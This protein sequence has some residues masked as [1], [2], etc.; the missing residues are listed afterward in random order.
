MV[1]PWPLIGRTEEL[2]RLRESTAPA[3]R[4]S[5]LSGPAGVGKT[6]LA[7]EVFAYWQGRGRRCR[8]FVGTRSAQSVP[9]AAH[10]AGVIV[11]DTDA[12]PAVARLAHPLLGEVRR[13]R[14]LPT[15][16]QELRSKVARELEVH[17]NAPAPIMLVRR[18]V[19]MCGSDL[20]PDSDLLID[21]ARAALR[22]SDPITA[23]RLAR[24]AVAAGGG[25]RAHWAHVGGLI[26]TQRFR[27]AYEMTTMP[28]AS[29]KSPRERVAMAVLAAVIKDMMV[30]PP[31]EN[32]L[33]ALENEAAE[34]A[35]GQCF[36]AHE[37]L[38]RQTAAQ[39]GDHNQ[40]QR[41]TELAAIVEG[42]RVAAATLHATSSKNG[43]CDGL[44]EAAGRYEQFGDRI[45][46][47]D[48]F[49]QASNLLRDRGLRGAALTAAASAE[50]LSASTGAAT[51]ALR[52]LRCPCPLTAR[53]REV[54]A[55]VAAGLTNRQIAEQLVTS[56]RTVEGHLF[57]ASQRTGISSRAGLAALVDHS[58]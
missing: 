24:H 18:A 56:I 48:T 1:A 19:L 35:R 53:Q 47:A 32:R 49:A 42:P 26:D 40:A 39:F 45:A 36:F 51:P 3:A 30:G 55:L 7:R 52:A 33:A 4:G 15:R 23:E 12:A 37:V 25:Y 22:L 6:R 10:R 38:C 46:A 34:T 8:W 57:R 16:L 41:L 5:V 58:P 29:A 50:R 2:D 9:L 17:D 28:A 43:D 21:A 54:I 31:G 44:C 11:L 14:S 27:E 20:A 13:A